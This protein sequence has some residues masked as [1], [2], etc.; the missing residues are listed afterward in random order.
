MKDILVLGMGKVGSLVG[1]LLSKKFKVKA[2]D[3][4]RP[5]YKYNL[6]FECIEGD[7][8]NLEFIKEELKNHDAVVSAL[9]YYLNKD[10]AQI[11]HDLEVHYFD[12]TEYVPTTKFIQSLSKT[13]ESLLAP[14]CGMAPGLIRIIGMDLTHSFDQLR[15]IEL[16]VGAL[17]RYPNGQ[18][19]YSFTWSPHGVINEYFNDAEAIHNGKRKLVP[20]LDG[21]EYINIEGQEF[22]A[23]T[24][25]GGLGTL[26]ET[27]EGKVDTLNYKTIRYPGHGKLMRFLMYELILKEDKEQ[28]ERIFSNAK[29]PVEED[30]VYVYAV[31]EG[32]QN[33]TLSRKEYY[34]A[35]HP[36]EIAGKKWR[37]ISWTTAASLVAVVEMVASGILPQKGF[38]KQEEIPFEKF[39]KTPTG[40]LFL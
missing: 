5:H 20:S 39:L 38:L 7:V 9:P 28:L 22:E 18:L 40:S 2:I 26:C 31:V 15:D 6:P 16:R 23:F 34:K 27:F 25:S 8:S 36:I 11:A 24:T 10:I 32:W 13:S 35:F 33:M 29:P 4:K 37:A 21:F 30:V 3:K 19:A 1:V 12:L 17:P 14:Q